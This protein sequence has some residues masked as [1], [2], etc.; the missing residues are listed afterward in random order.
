M[1]VRRLGVNLDHVATL[2]QARREGFPNPSDYID[3]LYECGVYQM[4]LHVREDRR[5]MCEDDLVAATSSQKLPV[6]LEMA[7]TNEML[8]LAL[9]YK[10]HTC[11]LVPE[12]REEITTEGGLDLVTHRNSLS[13]II[14][15]LKH[16]GILVSLFIDPSK[17]QVSMAAHLGANAIEI[18]TGTYA[19]KFHSI[20]C[21][22]ELERIIQSTQLATGCGLKVFAGHG[23]DTVNLPPLV[24]IAGIQEYNI[25]FSIIARSIMVG[26]KQAIMEIQKVL[27]GNP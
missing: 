7:G 20:E 16:A 23:L 26:L 27:H 25:G 14:Q 24:R 12:K 17:E 5:H 2:R 8:A 6:N 22:A 1:L 19:R 11:T 15:A 4:T 18:H 3:V 13:K 9:K 10:P 21:N